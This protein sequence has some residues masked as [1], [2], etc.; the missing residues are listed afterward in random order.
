[1]VLSYDIFSNWS[2]LLLQFEYNITK[3]FN[4]INNCMQIPRAPTGLEEYMEV[5]TRSII[6]FPL[7]ICMLSTVYY[8]LPG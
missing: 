8:M 5:D 1:M 6:F 7:I 3:W 4:I 2:K